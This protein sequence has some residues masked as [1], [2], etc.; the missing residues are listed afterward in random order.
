MRGSVPNGGRVGRP[1]LHAAELGC[2]L[3]IPVPAGG[4]R[5]GR[6]FRNSSGIPQH[7][8]VFCRFLFLPEKSGTSGIS[9][10][11]PEFRSNPHP[12]C[13]Q[14]RTS[15]GLAPQGRMLCVG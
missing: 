4:V 5:N 11:P 15:Y 6:K 3:L 13:A 9:G 12:S 8:R 14:D 7:L 2:E 10:V 1:Q